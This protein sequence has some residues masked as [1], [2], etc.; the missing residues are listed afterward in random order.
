MSF[1][2]IG[3]IAEVSGRR[4]IS[5]DQDHGPL[6]FDKRRCAMSLAKLRLVDDVHLRRLSLRVLVRLV[7]G[8]W[9][10][11]NGLYGVRALRRS[12]KGAVSFGSNLPEMW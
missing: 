3:S 11:R 4:S 8:R 12:W 10:G 5:M 6:G 1:N 9:A 7:L 2:S